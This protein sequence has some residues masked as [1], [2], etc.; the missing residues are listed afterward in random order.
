MKYL[1]DIADKLLE[2][3]ITPEEAEILSKNIKNYTNTKKPVSK[4]LYLE[5]VG[6]LIEIKDYNE[7]ILGYITYSIETNIFDSPYLILQDTKCFEKGKGHFSKMFNKLCDT[8][9]KNRAEYIDLEVDK[10]NENAQKIYE[11]LGFSKLPKDG[12]EDIDNMEKMRYF[13]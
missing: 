1:D 13:I 2:G 7:N 8:A 11:H 10:E 3:T 9:Q 5:D 12:F 4:N 6:N